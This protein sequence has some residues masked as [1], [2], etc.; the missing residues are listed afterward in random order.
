MPRKVIHIRKEVAE[1]DSAM[2][3]LADQ[4]VY[5]ADMLELES[6]NVASGQASALRNAAA[7]LRV[8]CRIL[9]NKFNTTGIVSG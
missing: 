6:T 3:R 1:W 7:E 2:T 5:K 8:Q 4:W 9:K